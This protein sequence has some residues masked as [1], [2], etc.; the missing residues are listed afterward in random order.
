MAVNVRT[1]TLYD[2][3]EIMA[4]GEALHAESPRYAMCSYN[5]AKVEALARQVIPA[6]GAHVAEMNGKIIGMI[7]GF[8][9]DRWFGDDKMASDYTFYV[10]PEHRKGR[11]ALLLVRA[12]EGW[13][14]LNGALDIVPGTSTMLDAE[15]TARFYEKLGYERSGYGF[16]KR[17][18]HGT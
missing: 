14:Y 12:F 2:L 18:V 10:K 6:G 13:A 17:I 1:A 16:F 11:A 4:M 3:P 7:A 9:V 8:V 5:P 15:G